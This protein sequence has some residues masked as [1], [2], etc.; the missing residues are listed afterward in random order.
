MKKKVKKHSKWVRKPD[1]HIKKEKDLI[2][3][4]ILHTRRQTLS[5]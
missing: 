4:Y 1:K 2:M 5:I 3:D